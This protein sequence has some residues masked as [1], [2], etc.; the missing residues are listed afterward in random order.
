MKSEDYQLLSAQT[1]SEEEQQ[2]HSSTEMES[3]EEEQ[4]TPFRLYSPRFNCEFPEENITDFYPNNRDAE[5]RHSFEEDFV[6]PAWYESEVIVNPFDIDQILNEGEPDED[7]EPVE[8]PGHEYENYFRLLFHR[9]YNKRSIFFEGK[10]YK[11]Y[12]DFCCADE[13]SDEESESSYCTTEKSSYIYISDS[14]DEEDDATF[15]NLPKEE[16]DVISLCI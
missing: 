6:V 1:E 11:S 7:F 16:Q 4:Y 8:S 5:I 13:E 14:E 12:H 3:E 15:F 2:Q 9:E 10:E